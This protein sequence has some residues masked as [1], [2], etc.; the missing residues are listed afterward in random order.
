MRS[1]LEKLEEKVTDATNN[2]NT[3]KHELSVLKLELSDIDRERLEED[4]APMGRLYCQRSTNPRLADD[5]NY[6]GYDEYGYDMEG[7]HMGLVEG[8]DDKK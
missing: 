3:V 1:T 6:D 8:I 4:E 7:N 2:L 5:N